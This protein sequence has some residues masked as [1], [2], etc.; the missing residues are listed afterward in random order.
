MSSQVE[1]IQQH[2]R[3]LSEAVACIRMRLEQLALATENRQVTESRL[4]QSEGPSHQG[5]ELDGGS[6][7]EDKAKK[8]KVKEET[9]FATGEGIPSTLKLLAEILELSRFDQCVLLLCM[10]MELDTRIAGLCARAQGDMNKP[11]PTFALAFAL[12]DAPDWQSLSPHHPLRHWRLLEI[13]RPVSQTLIGAALTI[14]ERIVAFIKGV[15][16]MD[17]RLSVLIDP[18]RISDAPLPPSQQKQVDRIIHRLHQTNSSEP[19]PVIELAD[20]DSMEKEQIAGQAA[21]SLKVNLY[22]FDLNVLPADTGELESF[23]RLW[24]REALLLSLA[25]YIRIDG[26]SEAERTR[27]RRFLERGEGVFFLDLQD[28]NNAIIRNR[29]TV[30]VSKP[31]TEEQEQLWKKI[32]PEQAGALPQR[33]AEQFSFGAGE[34]RQLARQFMEQSSEQ[35]EKQT[36]GRGLWHLCRLAARSGME[37]LAQ[38]IEVKANWKQLVL[39]AEQKALLRQITGQVA[40]RHQVYET[41]GFRQR[42]NRGLGITA[43]F[44]GPSGTGKT[45]AA[46]VIAKGLKLDLFCIDLS[47]VVSKYIGETEKNLRKLFDTAEDSGAILFFDEADALFGKRSEV[48][49]SHDRYANIEI[50]YLLQ[51]IETYRGL[52]ILASNVRTA[53]DKAFTRRLRFIVEF[54]FP[55][56]DQRR[57]IWENV[58][59]KDTLK[60]DNLDYGRLA[61]LNL[62]GGNIHNVALNAAFLAAA[63]EAEQQEAEQKSQGNA[64]KNSVEST[65][66]IT[67]NHILTAAKAEFRKL[68]R[69]IKESDFR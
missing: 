51:R 48:K 30:E 65:A 13:N 22:S 60:A 58:F 3:E 31:T 9:L 40:H 20:H 33:L 69:P 15:N 21:V 68:D 19:P 10:A 23:T 62:T 36:T 45:M 2:D 24:N 5:E 67:M 26:V 27:L 1:W 38:R 55:C 64:E 43:L 47:S 54:P 35:K 59:P 28:T 57:K 46:G 44:T 17:D 6:N 4:D 49:D 32:L 41:W 16:Y 61:R 14:D 53:L 29:F 52:A 7:S 63:D 50:N 37:Q 18:M 34:I 66:E 56:F 42:M 25:L 8:D 11:Y 39:P 12:F